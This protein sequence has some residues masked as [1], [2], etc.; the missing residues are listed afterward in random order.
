MYLRGSETETFR[1]SNTP[2]GVDKHPCYVL[3]EGSCRHT[4]TVPDEV[5]EILLR[6]KHHQLRDLDGENDNGMCARNTVSV[7]QGN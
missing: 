7:Q 2:N 3:R 5:A 1:K 4:D 6:S